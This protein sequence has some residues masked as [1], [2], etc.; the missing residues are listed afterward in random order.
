MSR[1]FDVVAN[2]DAQEAAYRPYLVVLQSDLVSGLSSTVI[3]PLVSR[4]DM[5][6]ATR[7]NPLV[8]IDGREFWL[9]THELF[10][11]DRRILGKTIASLSEQRDAIIAAIDFVFTGF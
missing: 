10:A 3:A 8:N 4:A 1:Q 6:G 9:A 11:V 5:T 7:M 2:P